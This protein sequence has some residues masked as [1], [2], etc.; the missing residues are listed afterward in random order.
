M[1]KEKKEK[2]IYYED[3]LNDEFS[4]AKIT[5]K[6]IDEH[7]HYLHKTI[8]GSIF[9]AFL[10]RCVLIPFAFFYLKIKFHHK[11]VGKEK[12]KKIK[13][14][15]YFIYGNHTQI[16]GDA[17]IPTFLSLPRG[18]FVIVHP[19]NV[20]MKVLGKMN[21]Y[22]GAIPLPDDLKAT[23]N[24]MKCIEKRLSQK[25][26]ICIYPER[27]LWPYYTKIRPFL[28]N[29]FHY[30]VKYNLP[31]FCFTNTYQKRKNPNKVK[32]TT[33]IEGPFYIDPSLSV[34][35]NKKMLR[36]LCFNAMEENSKHSNVE[37]IKYIKK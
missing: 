29:N 20:S 27:H 23:K 17:F 1:S 25:K 11:I 34:N 10:Y 4:D 16:V 3:E 19:A 28:D 26:A 5:P 15:G 18:T 24:F 31:C 7:Y 14:S 30:P 12:L 6:K 37:L 36:D 8:F 32:I 9:H 21:E 22:L 2:I 35:E 33:Y 13:N